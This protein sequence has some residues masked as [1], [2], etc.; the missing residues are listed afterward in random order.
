[1][2]KSRR[3]SSKRVAAIVA[4][5]EAEIG[6]Q[7]VSE[8][9]TVPVPSITYLDTIPEEVQL[10]TIFCGVVTANARKPEAAQALIPFLGSPEA[11]SALRRTELEPLNPG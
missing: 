6:I 8:I 4:C 2:L 10:P 3:V 7:P 5:G 9:V 1:M 11:A